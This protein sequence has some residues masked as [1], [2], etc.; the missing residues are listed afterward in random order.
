MNPLLM[1]TS[2]CRWEADAFQT[3]CACLADNTEGGQGCACSEAACAN[4]TSMMSICFT[5][6]MGSV[7]CRWEA[8]A[9]Q[10]GCACLADNMECGQGC[11]C[12]EATCA[13]RAISRRRALVVGQDVSEGNVWGMDC[14]TRK[15][16][17]DGTLAAV[18]C[19]SS[20]SGIDH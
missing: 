2:L 7:C 15:N 19:H 12:S 16:I 6:E 17:L 8:E 13:N 18:C 3:G 10:T 1:L 14:Y 20:L 9:F 5:A 4:C 11:A